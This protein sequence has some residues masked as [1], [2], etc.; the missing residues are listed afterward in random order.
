MTRLRTAS[1]R[2]LSPGAQAGSLPH[3]LPPAAGPRVEGSAI[4]MF[5]I[6]MLFVKH[7][8]I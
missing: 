8:L 1:R 6:K 7:T 3:Q 4:R 5:K 2:A